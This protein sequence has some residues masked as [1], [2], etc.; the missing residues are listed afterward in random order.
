VIAELDVH[1]EIDSHAAMCLQLAATAC[2]VNIR[3]R[4]PASLTRG[5]PCGCP[6]IVR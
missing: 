2:R 5:Q 3:A 6:R 4:R 1:G